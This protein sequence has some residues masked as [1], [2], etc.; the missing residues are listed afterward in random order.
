M[1][2]FGYKKGKTDFEDVLKWTEN[3][4]TETMLK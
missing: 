4:W 2:P 1:E 3:M